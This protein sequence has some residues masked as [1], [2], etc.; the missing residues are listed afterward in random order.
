M[1]EEKEEAAPASEGLAGVRADFVASLGRKV[2]DARKALAAKDGLQEPE[3]FLG[4]RPFASRGGTVTDE[5]IYRLR[6][7]DMV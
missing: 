7:E 5:Q 1:A 2:G 6:E 3:E 4:F